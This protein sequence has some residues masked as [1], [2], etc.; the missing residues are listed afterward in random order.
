MN[1]KKLT[2]D[3]S[4]ST[5]HILAMLFMLMDHTW[6]VLLPDAVWLTRVGRLAFPIFAFFIV[7]GCFRT[8]DRKKYLLRMLF[9]A[10]ISEVPFDLMY[11]GMP[12]YPYHQ[13][14]M[15]TFAIAMLG[16]F[17]MEK[18]K[19]KKNVFLTVVTDI[20][21]VLGTSLLALVAMTDYNAAGVLTVYVF[22]IFRGRKW[23]CYVG[24][25]VLLYWLNVEVL[26]GLCYNVTIFGH[27]FEIVQQGL[28]LLALPLVWLYRDRKGITGK[29]F[30]MF[31]YLFYPVHCL[32]LSLLNGLF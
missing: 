2:F 23:W 29:P 12:V 14:V 5:L 31:C 32:L 17:G 4:S 7:E 28:A 6:A 1:E 18:I 21:I 9:F 22:Y 19:E 25:A 10:V 11:G 16:I 26:S 30:Q 20:G 15:W 3:L 27:E 13:N 24:Q 8:H